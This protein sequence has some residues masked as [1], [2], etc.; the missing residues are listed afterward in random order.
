MKSYQSLEMIIS[1][2]SETQSDC[3]TREKQ[4]ASCMER[5]VNAQDR[6]N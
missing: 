4:R 3:A 2:I 1:A 6:N 5:D